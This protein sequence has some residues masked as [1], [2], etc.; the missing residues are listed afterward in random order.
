MLV[1]R[2]LMTSLLM[3]ILSGCVAIQSFPNVA[4]GGD[5]I[6]LAVGSPDG[7]TKENTTATYISDL[8]LVPV[9]I[10]IRSIVRIRPDA[11]SWAAAYDSFLNAETYYTGHSS[12]LSVVVIDLPQGLTVGTGTINI[13]TSASF[14]HLPK[15]VND[16]PISIEVIEGVGSSNTFKYDNGFGGVSDGDI[17]T[18]QPL[19]QV[20]ISPPPPFEWEQNGIAAAEIKV[21]VPMQSLTGDVV[22]TRVI[23]VIS[24]DIYTKNSKSQLQL[25]WVRNGDDFTINL[26]SPVATMEAVQSRFSILI[27]PP[28]EFIST[29]GPRVLSVKYFDQD[30][31]LMSL[32]DGLPIADLFKA[33]IQY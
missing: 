2:V 14:G 8:D 15:G 18:L 10:P 16:I 11:T 26:I 6:T 4:R 32:A 24:D 21:R 20:V 31:R 9:E 23:R 25:S 27:Q 29:P 13:A 12:W 1:F 7:M 30:G 5:T 19:K 22:P 28:N 3:V 33:E 17:A